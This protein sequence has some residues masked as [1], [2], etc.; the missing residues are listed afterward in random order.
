MQGPLTLCFNFRM[1]SIVFGLL[2]NSAHV[3]QHISKIQQH[4]EL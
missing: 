4:K 3:T 2:N 1:K